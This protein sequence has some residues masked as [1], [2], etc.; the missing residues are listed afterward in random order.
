MRFGDQLLSFEESERLETSFVYDPE[1]I[2]TIVRSLLRPD[3]EH[4]VREAIT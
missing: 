4:Q 1:A 3:Q 2:E